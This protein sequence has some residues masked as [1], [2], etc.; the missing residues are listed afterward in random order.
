MTSFTRPSKRGSTLNFKNGLLKNG[1][2]LGS[3]STLGNGKN[4]VIRD[5]SGLGSGRALGNVKNGVIRDGSSTGSGRALGS[6]KNGAIY[7]GSSLGAG[8]KIGSV[9]DILK[10]VKGLD[11]VDDATAVA[12][13]HFLVKEIF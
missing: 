11:N 13:Y 1:S 4:G 6:A 3:G 10:K 5:G 7:N 12:L 2:G 9:S 8:K